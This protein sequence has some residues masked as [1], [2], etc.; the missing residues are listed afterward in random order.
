MDPDARKKLKAK[1]RKKKEER[2]QGTKV[3]LEKL[4]NS[5][6]GTGGEETDIM[7]MM[8]NVNRILQS[9]PQMVQQVS[10]CVSNVINNKQLMESLAGQ[11]QDQT[12]DSNEPSTSVAASEK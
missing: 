11:L 2:T 9:N 3:T 6:N 5:A 1:L 10:K 4:M 8:E 12:L 7:K